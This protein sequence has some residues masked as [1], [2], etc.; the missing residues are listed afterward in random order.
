M[1]GQGAADEF[2][3]LTRSGVP[4]Y[5]AGCSIVAA[6]RMPTYPIGTTVMRGLLA[7]SRGSCDPE[8]F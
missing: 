1:S 5:M 3:D 2:F 4:A 7:D 8:P 6:S